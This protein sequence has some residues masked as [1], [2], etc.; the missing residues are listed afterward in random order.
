MAKAADFLVEIGTEELPPKALKGL[1]N[2]FAD[3][4]DKALDDVNIEHGPMSAYA[5]PRRLAVF[6]ADLALTQ[7]YEEVEVKGPP[8]SIAYDDK[9]ELTAAGSAF[10]KKFDVSPEDL[11]TIDTDKGKRL[12]YRQDVGGVNASTLI[13]AAV[14]VAL[15]NLPIPRRMR[16]GD[17]DTEFVRPIHWI[18][19]LHGK[20]T[21]E[22]PVM[23]VRAGRTTRGHRFLAP[24]ETSIAAPAKYLADLKKAHVLADFD[25]RRKTIV[26]AVEKAAKEAGGT[27]VDSDALYDEVT[28]LTEW[29]VP[30]TGS[31]DES[32]LSLPKEVIVATL[33]SHQ[34]YFPVADKNG[35]LL[36]RFIAIANLVSKE[37]DRVRDGNER[38]IRPRLADAAFFW[39]ADKRVSLAGRCDAVA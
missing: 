25:A 3:G 12:V 28:A 17:R 10:A 9:G 38:V 29:P 30:L 1:M 26:E 31:F 14:E 11:K 15:F 21:I 20:D 32:F 34:R 19:M 35:N 2:A 18:V 24:Q 37:P 36:P 27:P 13:P 8:V 33:T 4:L 16:W 22:E 39:E 23:G 6:I 5:S 7:S